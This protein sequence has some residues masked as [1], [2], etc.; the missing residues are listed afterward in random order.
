MQQKSQPAGQTL[1]V[2]SSHIASFCSRVG[3]SKVSSRLRRSIVRPS[4]SC[5][6]IRRSRWI[7]LDKDLR[8][9]TAV[10]RLVLV[11]TGDGDGP[12]S[13]LQSPPAGIVHLSSHLPFCLV[14]IRHAHAID[15]VSSRSSTPRGGQQT[16]FASVSKVIW[17]KATRHFWGDLACKNPRTRYLA[18]HRTPAFFAENNKPH[19]VRFA[20]DCY[21]TLPFSS[22]CTRVISESAI[23]RPCLL[24]K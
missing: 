6:C 8:R 23:R 7:H 17:S 1:S 15:G 19:L 3:I 2:V 20:N 10:I 9:R 4:T 5:G 14:T 16:R 12:A 21:C 22:R 18:A 11:E 13:T 24:G